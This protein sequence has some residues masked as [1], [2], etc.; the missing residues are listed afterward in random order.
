MNIYIVSMK[1]YLFKSLII[2]LLIHIFSNYS[3]GGDKSDIPVVLNNTPSLPTGYIPQPFDVISYDADVDLF[4][5]PKTDMTGK[6]RIKAL[7][8]GQKDTSDFIFHLMGL[9]VDSV[10][11]YNTKINFEKVNPGDT[12]TF[13]YKF[14]LGTSGIPVENI[15]SEDTADIIVFYSGTM[16]S[17]MNNGQKGWGGVHSSG[18]ILYSMGVGF[19][20]NYISTTRHWLPC[21]DHPSDK[22]V[23]TGRFRVRK[24]MVCASVGLPQGVKSINDTVAEYEWKQTYPCATYLYTFAVAKYSLIQYDA[25]GVPYYLYT[26]AK[27]SVNT[28][29]N[30]KL[31]PLMVKAFEKRFGKYPFEKVGYANTPTGSM[32]HQTLISYDVSLVYAKDTVN[33]IAAHELAHQWFGDHVSCYDYRDTWLSEG[34]ATFC[35]AIWAEE[36][37]NYRKYLDVLTDKIDRYTINYSQYEGVFSL[38]D[39]PRTGFSS[40]YPI[41][42]YYKGGA[43]LGM[44]RYK[45]GDEKFFAGIKSYINKYGYGNTTTELLKSELE[46]VSGTELDTFF[47]QWIYGKGW[48]LLKISLNKYLKS[49]DIADVKIDIEQEQIKEYGIFT[50][51]PVEFGFRMENG[52]YYY[53]TLILDDS[54]QS[55]LIKDIPNTTNEITINRG[56]SVRSLMQVTKLSILNTGIGE[57]DN[58]ADC[59]IYPNPAES[60]LN[61]QSGDIKGV[62]NFRI[63]DVFGNS[64]YSGILEQGITSLDICAGSLNLAAGIYFF[65]TNYNG[66][67]NTYTFSVIK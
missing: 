18:G 1:K 20:N 53:H 7:I 28:A 36:L 58:M 22:A 16:T 56:P 23:F 11:Y 55:F 8:T 66:I 67:Q 54:V 41:T 51:L 6:C 35:E 50:G 63:T 42:I 57:S 45:L 25:E 12:A 44:L 39:Y 9:N 64:L 62:I 14:S 61:I 30:F 27:D 29:Y 24:G 40:N 52:E 43:V 31:L 32:E 33:I 65:I 4:S 5:A 3:F 2:L 37:L 46:K 59:Q 38:Y 34:F 13:H 26:L 48:P 15:S 47:N 60:I 21:Y 17:E 49:N 19:K 10:Y